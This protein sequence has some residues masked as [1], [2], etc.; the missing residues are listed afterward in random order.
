MC[1]ET[2]QH[3]NRGFVSQSKQNL[4]ESERCGRVYLGAVPTGT[5]GAADT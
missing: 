1:E 3:I 4:I 2:Q 5:L